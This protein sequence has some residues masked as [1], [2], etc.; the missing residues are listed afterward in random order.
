M[1]GR[2][3]GAPLSALAVGCG[4]AVAACE[5]TPAPAITSAGPPLNVYSS[6]P[7]ARVRALA[8]AYAAAGGETIRYNL[9]DADA[10]IARLEAR[11]DQ[12][13]AD[14]LLVRGNAYLGRAVE[15]D[16]LRPVGA[17]VDLSAIPADLGDPD[18]YWLGLAVR[19][20]VIVYDPERVAPAALGGYAELADARWRGLL[21]LQTSASERM[22]SLVAALIAGLGA[23]DAELA[24]R[25]WSSNLATAAFDTEDALLR[26]VDD[27][28]CAVA[29]AGADAVAAF[30]A[31]EPGSRVGAHWPDDSAIGTAVNLTG[32]GVSRHAGSPDQA[33]RFLAWLASAEGQRALVEG[34]AE[35][36][37]NPAVTG[38]TVPGAPRG[39]ARGPITVA[40]LGYFQ[41]DAERLLERARLP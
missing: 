7:E 39:F 21:C 18:R 25:G 13:P 6:L 23:R 5:R 28:R 17:A 22:R 41:A 4:L 16:V 34:T 36:P 31:G 8:D 19:P 33:A 37:A 40:A 11:A 35:R 27:G 24:V 30:L 3:R 2:R 15:A 20:E 32:A 1:T 10:L 12:P 29:I 26:A 14:L 38:A 9:G